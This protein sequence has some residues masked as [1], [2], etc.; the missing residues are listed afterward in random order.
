MLVL[1]LINLVVFF[2][3]EHVDSIRYQS[4]DVIIYPVKTG[5]ITSRLC[6]YYRKN[7]NTC[8]FGKRS[9]RAIIDFLCR[10]KYTGKWTATKT[11]FK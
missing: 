6:P 9:Q 11:E 10:M 4:R 2:K 7:I 5:Y 1:K 8:I 3:W